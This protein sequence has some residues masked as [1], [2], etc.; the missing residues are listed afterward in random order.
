MFDLISA[1]PELP[2]WALIGYLL[3]SVPFGIVIAR[4]FGLGDIRKVGSGNIGATNVLRTGNKLAA[5]L[6]LLLDAFKGGIVVLLAR[7]FAGEDAAQI[8]AFSA[9]LGHC[10]PVWL[11]FKGGKGVATYFGTVFALSPM[12]GI[13]AG[14]LWL[15]AAA[16]TR[17]SSM[18]A[19]ISTLWTPFLVLLLDMGPYFILLTAISVLVVIRHWQNIKRI[20]AGTEPKIGQK[21]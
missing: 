13:L 14:A 21:S 6:T 20:K 9:I 10:F 5:L 17:T 18:A 19:L 4:L 11:G 16:V 8:G 15:F 1:S 2:L 7:Y 3:G 12:I